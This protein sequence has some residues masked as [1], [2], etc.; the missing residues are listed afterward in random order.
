MSTARTSTPSRRI[1]EATALPMPLAAPV[2][3]PRRRCD[4]GVIRETPLVHLR[5]E[6]LA[7][8]FPRS[9]R[10]VRLDAPPPIAC[11]RQAPLFA[12]TILRHRRNAQAYS[13]L[14]SRVAQARTLGYGS[15]RQVFRFREAESTGAATVTARAG[16]ARR[17]GRNTPRRHPL[18]PARHEASRAALFLA[19]AGLYPWLPRQH[20]RDQGAALL[21]RRLYRRDPLRERAEGGP[22]PSGARHSRPR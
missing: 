9:C 17:R 1:L 12:G 11:R 16:R 6:D 15:P 13:G 8:A 18:S 2:T 19:R 22:R 20:R 10:I 4:G 5:F 3:T 21:D 7:R 14:A